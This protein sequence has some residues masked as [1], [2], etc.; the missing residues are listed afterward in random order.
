MRGIPLAPSTN[1]MKFYSEE[2]RI[3]LNNGVTGIRQ[4]R[5]RIYR[6]ADSNDKVL[7]AMLYLHGGGYMLGTPEA[8]FPF[9]HQILSRRDV[10]I[11]APDYRLTPEDPY[12]AGFEDSYGTLLWMKEQAD[13]LKIW[14]DHFILAGHSAGGG[15]VAGLT[16]KARATP[17]DKIHI[18]L[19]MPIYPMLDHRMET[20]SAKDMDGAPLWNSQVNRIAWQY[21][22]KNINVDTQDVPIF[23]SPALNQDYQGYPPTVSFVGDLEPFYHETLDYMETIQKAGIPTKFRVFSG[24]FHSFEVLAPNTTLSKE[25]WKFEA[26]AFEEFFDLYVVNKKEQ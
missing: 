5:L 9:Y 1:G 13:T 8:W 7:P 3:P 26:E 20:D 6:R 4:L 11:V 16:L 25:A 24:A 10:C 19:I 17:Q 18:A 22:L 15:L 14:D 2:R 21:Y 23:A 12:P